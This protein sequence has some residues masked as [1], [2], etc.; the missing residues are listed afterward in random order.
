MKMNYTKIKNRF[1]L[2][3]INASAKPINYIYNKNPAA[4]PKMNQHSRN[5]NPI[6]R[7]IVNLSNFSEQPLIK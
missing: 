6:A 1:A 4:V 5:L 2:L 7:T 3:E